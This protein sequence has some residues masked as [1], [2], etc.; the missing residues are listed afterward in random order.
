MRPRTKRSAP[1][2]WIF[3]SRLGIQLQKPLL[4][5]HPNWPFDRYRFA[6]A[7]TDSQ[8]LLFP[9]EGKG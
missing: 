9:K 2:V 6:E 8:L 5:E 1:D 3:E 7:L 4:Q